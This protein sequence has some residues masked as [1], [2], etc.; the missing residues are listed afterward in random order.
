MNDEPCRYEY[1]VDLGDDSAATYVTQMTGHGK[2]VLDVGCGP[3]SITKVLAGQGQC[4]V[5]GLELD[6]ASIERVQ[7]YC[8]E[9]IQADLNS[10]DWPHLLDGSAGFDVV[11][12]AD[13]LEHLY[14]P[15]TA[16]QLMVPLLAPGGSVVVSLPHAGHAAV[17][18]CLVSGDFAYREYGLLDHTHIRFFCLKNIEELFARAG[19]KIVEARYVMT[20]PEKTELAESW[21]QV[22]ALL[23]AALESTPHAH[24]YQVVVRAVPLDAPGE[25]VALEA[26]SSRPRRASK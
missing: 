3:G 24:V 15:W 17:A 19:L 16:L 1:E 7:A 4:I 14:D 6:Q 2:R 12:A 21:S 20:S 22:P 8:A 26:P 5:T 11:V 9:V 23:Q 25:A 10:S 13:V 18:A